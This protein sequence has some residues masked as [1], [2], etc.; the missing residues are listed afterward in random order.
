MQDVGNYNEFSFIKNSLQCYSENEE[1]EKA[2]VKHQNTSED[3]E[4]DEDNM[5]E[6]ERMTNQNDRKFIAG[7]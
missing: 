1:C 3:K 4:A 2:I 6:H 7:L 5:T